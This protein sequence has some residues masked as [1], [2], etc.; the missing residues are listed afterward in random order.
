MGIRQGIRAL[1]A[2]AL[3][4]A[5]VGDRVYPGAAPQKASLPFIVVNFT[6][7]DAHISHGGR[8]AS[9]DRRT[10]TVEAHSSSQAEAEEIMES[11]DTVFAAGRPMPPGIGVILLDDEFDQIVFPGSG[12]DDKRRIVVQ[13]YIV[14]AA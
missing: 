4:T 11:V 7:L 8:D 3:I 1:L 6:G 14:W 5:K 2:D 13:G 12:G 10:L 9:A